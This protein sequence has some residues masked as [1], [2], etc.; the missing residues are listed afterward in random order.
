[1]S[2]ILVTGPPAAGK[3]SVAEEL[4]S[5]RE[6][7]AV[8]NVDEL[9]QMVVRPKAEPW[10]GDDGPLQQ[11]LGVQNACS[12]VCNYEAAGYDS[13]VVDA[14]TDAML[15]QYR[16]RLADM[17]VWIVQL[18]PTE[19]EIAGRLISRPDYLSRGEVSWLYDQQANLEGYDHRI[20]NSNMTT[21]QVV[22]WMLVRWPRG[23]PA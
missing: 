23:V 10:E 4:A 5:R 1:M 21:E 19:E 14:M 13:I 18:M 12:I 17:D 22:D 15:A 3:N 9:R 6:R 16:E 2:V 8:I 20:D 11:R 7:C